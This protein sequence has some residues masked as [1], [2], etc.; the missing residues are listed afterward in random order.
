MDL[1]LTE[2]QIRVLRYY[3]DYKRENG[4]APTLEEAAE[5]LGVSKITIYEHL[6]H[7]QRK[8][9]IHRDKAKARAVS[10]LFDPDRDRQVAEVEKALPLLGMIAAGRPIEALEDREDILL[11]D[12]IP[13]GDGFYLLRVKGKSMIEDHIDDGDLV[14]IER[15]E[16]ARD[17]EIV[18]AILNGGEAT[19]KRFYRDNGRVRLQPANASMAPIYP[20]EC[21]IRG[22]VRGVVR[23]FR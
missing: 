17:G 4:I 20:N 18:V 11:D 14:V 23:R 16:T 5:A 2:K 7:L 10:I 9:A 8:G 15:R 19:L 22:V 6:S 3:R 21:E 13:T 1:M 12:L